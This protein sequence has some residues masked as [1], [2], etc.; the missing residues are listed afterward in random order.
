MMGMGNG[1]L[2]GAVGS[3]FSPKSGNNFWLG[4]GPKSL[5]RD[6]FHGFLVKCFLLSVAP[7]TAMSQGKNRRGRPIYSR[8][9]LVMDLLSSFRI[10]QWERD[11]TVTTVG[12]RVC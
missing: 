1:W 6:D 8:P 10:N 5:N 11:T 9:V 4:Q 2:D 12:I 7:L 3:Y